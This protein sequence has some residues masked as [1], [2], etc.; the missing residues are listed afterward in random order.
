MRETPGNQQHENGIAEFREPSGPGLEHYLGILWRRKWLSL[1]VFFLVF[2]AA[3]VR[4]YRTPALYRA[5]ATVMIESSNQR[6]VMSADYMIPTWNM[7]GYLQNH[8]QLLG[9]QRVQ[10]EIAA[11]MPH[12]LIQSASAWIGQDSSAVNPALVLTL[13]AMSV[14]PIGETDILSISVTSASPDLAVGLANLYAEGYQQYDLVQG[15][16]D[17]SS[18]REFI[19]EQLNVVGRRLDIAEIGLEEFKKENRFIDLSAETNALIAQQS[20][21]AV[22]LA[23]TDTEL[24]GIQAQLTHV[25]QMIDEEGAGMSEKLESISSPLVASFKASLDEL[26]VERANLMMQGYPDSSALMQKLNRQITDVRGKLALESKRL[27]EN[28]GFIEPVGRL[29]ELWDEALALETGM[30][31]TLARKRILENSIVEHRAKLRTLPEVERTFAKLNRDVEADR[32]VYAMLSQRYEEA[33][34]QEAGRVSSVR[35]VDRARYGVKISPQTNRDLSIG[36]LVA[37]VLGVGISFAI[38]YFDKSV[39]SPGEVERYGLPVLANIPVLPSGKSGRARWG[40]HPVTTHLITHAD[41]S[42]SGAEAFRVL[43]TNLLFSGA[44]RPCKTIVVTSPGPS[45]GKSTVSVN[46]AASLA[47]AGHKTL[48]IDAD[49]R[50]PVLHSIFGH[51]RKPGFTDLVAFEEPSPNTISQAKL[52]NLYCL[53]SG[54]IPPSPADVLI[55]PETDRLLERLKKEYDYIVL[56]TPPA[57]LAADTAVLAAKVDAVL[58]VVKAGSTTQPAFENTLGHLSHSGGTLLGVVM[59]GLKASGRYGAY[60]Y[61]YYSGYAYKYKQKRRRALGEEDEAKQTSH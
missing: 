55:A 23:Q 29:R 37:L 11:I 30:T 56:D 45:E 48:L 59:N 39:R 49:L 18:I 4:T 52:E 21:L 34:I 28:Q 31:S 19:E 36:L 9:S 35:I 7:Q 5:N 61:Y 33:R 38:D 1:A 41:P 54:T 42:S 26:E 44:T 32:A 50:A 3:A 40:K 12:T 6:D 17:V 22:A 24:E 43:R 13:G 20:N 8:M 46:L 51:Q 15:R 25:R 2:V 16:A 57:L 60:Y 58:L 10:E 47:K 14:S 53:T 27:L